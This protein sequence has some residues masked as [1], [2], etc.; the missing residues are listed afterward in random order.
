MDLFL[1]IKTAIENHLTIAEFAYIYFLYANNEEGKDL[2]FHRLKPENKKRLKTLEYV[3]E[4]GD[5]TKKSLNLFKS[6][7]LNIKE[8]FEEFYKYYPNISIRPDGKVDP[9][10]VN[11]SACLQKYSSMI[12][13]KEQHDHII[14]CLKAQ[15]QHYTETGK[16][17]YFK[18]MLNWLRQ[19]G[20]LIGE[21][22]LIENNV[23]PQKQYGDEIQ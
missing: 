21:A 1:A 14:L 10:R 19:E 17:G 23:K 7:E 20:W 22:L 9:L 15:I 12:E 16:M 6:D 8:L 3:D 11:K 18:L 4:F 2:I 13:S 5:L